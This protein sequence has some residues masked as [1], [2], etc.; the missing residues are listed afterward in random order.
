MWRRLFAIVLLFG[1]L[2]AP[3]AAAPLLQPAEAFFAYLPVA[4]RSP[5]PIEFVVT[6]RG[7]TVGYP[8]HYYVYGYVRSLIAEQVDSVV[9]EIDVTIY[10]YDPESEGHVA[11]YTEAVRVSPALT[12][13][14]P[15]QINPFAWDLYLGKA[16]ASIGEV[17]AVD[18]R[19]TAPGGTIY[20]TL[21]VTGRHAEGTTVV[22]SVRNDQNHVL[23][24]VR[25]VVVEP[26]RCAWREATLDDTTLQPGQET[27]FHL[28]LYTTYCF[29]DDMVVLGQGAIQR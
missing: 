20:R 27:A 25:V 15:N 2:C 11:Q 7:E 3:S 8:T 16:S 6:T 14:L 4:A 29:T 19:R 24:D 17:R 10:S 28:N 26:Y 18:A 13:T 9:I 23:H 21:T 12:A 22:G 5:L 1:V